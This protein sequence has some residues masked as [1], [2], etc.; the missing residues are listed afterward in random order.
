MFMTDS[1]SLI[2]V[3]GSAEFYLLSLE[4]VVILS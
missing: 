1:D 4:L 2:N 3:Y